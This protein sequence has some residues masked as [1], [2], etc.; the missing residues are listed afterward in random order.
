MVPIP[1]YHNQTKYR[2]HSHSPRRRS[3][4]SYIDLLH[5]N[6]QRTKTNSRPTR[7]LR[8]H[9]GCYKERRNRHCRVSSHHRR[10]N[11]FDAASTIDVTSTS[12]HLSFRR[13]PSLLFSI[14]IQRVVKRHQRGW[15]ARRCVHRNNVR[16]TDANHR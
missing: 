3:Q 16:T 13:L 15:K 11:N 10:H 6:T 12:S 7:R 2:F 8:H 14:Q 9:F 5:P 1:R 4:H